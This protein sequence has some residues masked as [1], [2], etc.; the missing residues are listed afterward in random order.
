MRYLTYCIIAVCLLS[1]PCSA[2]ETDLL[3]KPDATKLSTGEYDASIDIIA[4]PNPT[5]G[6]VSI[7]TITSMD[8]SEVRVKLYNEEGTLMKEFA[9]FGKKVQPLD[10]SMDLSDFSNGTYF[11]YIYSS[12][13]L[14]TYGQIIKE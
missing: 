11:Y 10:L 7:M 4:Y 1:N 8:E 13:A 12:D 5:K 6:Q 9:N 14:V 2:Q 3:P